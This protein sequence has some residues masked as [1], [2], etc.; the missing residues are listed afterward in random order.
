MARKNPFANLMDGT[1]A[2]EGRVALDYTIKGASKSI[3]SSINEMASQ[4][5]KLLEGETVVEV[6]PS[7]IDVSFVRDRMADNDAEF[8]TL[9]EAIRERGQDSPVLLR[10]HPKQTGRYMVVFGHRRVRAAETLGRKVRA[11]IKQMD[12]RTHVIAQ[13]QENSARA[14]LS[15]IERAV[16][17]ERVAKLAYDND[18]RVVMTAL[19]VDRSTLS[20]MLSV[21]AIPAD[22]LEAIG[23]AKGIG[24]DRWYEMKQ[25][26]EKPA[27]LDQARAI[28]A[29]G[30]MAALS[31]DERFN[32]L[33][34]ALK[35]GERAGKT[36]A[37]R[38]SRTWS[39]D[40]KAVAADMS[41]DGRRFT[42]ALKARDAVSFGEFLSDRLPDLYDAFRKG[43]G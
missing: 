8:E 2:D 43:K 12:D 13:G 3:L 30:E 4:A 21:T 29:G 31:S 42:L 41:T 19:A 9:V 34:T 27:H 23:A 7:E 14:N 37:P 24:R 11:V 15:F 38:K 1:P 33:M 32:R 28:L 40:D 16:F 20:K 6:A 18:N 36:K 5:D 10:P 35:A 26:L 17:A 25:A 22:V 39:A